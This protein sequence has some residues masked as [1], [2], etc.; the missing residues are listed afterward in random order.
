MAASPGDGGLQEGQSK[1]VAVAAMGG[2]D[3]DL[4]VIP[5]VGFKFFP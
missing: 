1:S 2:V 3:S 4:Q 5:T